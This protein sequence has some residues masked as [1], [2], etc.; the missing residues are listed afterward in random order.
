[1]STPI[2][3]VDGKVYLDGA[4]IADVRNFSISEANDVK[5]YRSSSTVTASKSNQNTG[6]GG[7]SWE[8]SLG[9]FAPDGSFNPGFEIGDLLTFRG[10]A[11]TGK[12]V[13]GSCRVSS[14]EAE[15]DVEGV[16]WIG[17]SVSATG[18]GALTKTG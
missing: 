11:A 10:I 16:E 9:L 3:G 6:R 5:T 17:T 4:L 8:I 13:T 1:M 7:D 14:V 18:H 15:V 2:T 12:E